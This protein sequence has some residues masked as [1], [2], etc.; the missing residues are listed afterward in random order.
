MPQIRY[1]AMILFHRIAKRAITEFHNDPSD[2]TIPFPSERREW[3]SLSAG[4][5]AEPDP[6]A[7]V[8]PE[9]WYPIPAEAVLSVKTQM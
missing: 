6:A 3:H 4:N 9:E 8:L 7:S 1:A 5:P 2:I